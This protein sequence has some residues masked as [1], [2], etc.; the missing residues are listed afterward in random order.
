MLKLSFQKKNQ[1]LTLFNLYIFIIRTFLT[2]EQFHNLN[3]Y[4]NIV[5]VKFNLFF[6]I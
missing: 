3:I 6:Q 1:N 4:K 5:F 2:D